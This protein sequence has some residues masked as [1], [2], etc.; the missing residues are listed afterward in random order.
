MRTQE[1]ENIQEEKKKTKPSKK[2]KRAQQELFEEN[3]GTYGVARK[4]SKIT[5]K[6]ILIVFA[7]LFLVAAVGIAAWQIF[8]EK[9]TDAIDE[10]IE[11]LNDRNKN[12]TDCL[13]VSVGTMKKDFVMEYGDLLTEL[14]GAKNKWQ[15]NLEMLFSSQYTAL[16]ENFGSDFEVSYDVVEETELTENELRSYSEDIRDYLSN[17]IGEAQEAVELEKL[18]QKESERIIALFEKWYKEYQNT[19]VT[20]GYSV[21]VNITYSS[22]TKEKVVPRRMVVVLLDGEWVVRVGGLLPID[23]SQIFGNMQY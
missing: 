10:Q 17:G 18:T 13:E 1:N 9:Y 20:E 15:S 6:R 21:I 19:E 16:E 7:C 22:G 14:F 2:E 8:R 12:L 23:S 5:L 3:V 4:K 11:M